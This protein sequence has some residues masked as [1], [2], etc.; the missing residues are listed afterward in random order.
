[1]ATA[2]VGMQ[3]ANADDGVDES[4]SNSDSGV[5]DLP[6][7]DR[8]VISHVFLPLTCRTCFV[9]LHDSYLLLLSQRGGTHRQLWN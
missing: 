6:V 2:D 7:D 8:G 3:S 4:D 1:M 5:D 9:V